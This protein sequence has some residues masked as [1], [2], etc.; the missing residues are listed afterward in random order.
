MEVVKKVAVQVWGFMAWIFGIALLVWVWTKYPSLVVSIL[1]FNLHMIKLVCGWVPKPFNAMAESALRVGL[2][3]DKAL[4]FIEGKLVVQGVMFALRKGVAR[5]FAA[6][7]A[8][9]R[10]T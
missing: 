7:D 9:A 3:A 4:L 2:G 1:D 8:P 5:L 6:N 10:R